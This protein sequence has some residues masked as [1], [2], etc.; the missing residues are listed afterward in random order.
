MSN[1]SESVKKKCGYRCVICGSSEKLEAH[2]II[3]VSHDVT[4]KYDINNGIA[5]C[6]GCHFLTHHAK[7]RNHA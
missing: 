1:W 3:P 5:L 4:H 2:H 6:H 7:K